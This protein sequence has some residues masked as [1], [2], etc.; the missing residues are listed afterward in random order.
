MAKI[1]RVLVS[2]AW[3]TTFP[4]ARVKAL[5]RFPSNHNPLLVDLGDNAFFWEKKV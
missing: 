1:D 2:T 4:L 5:E 3:E